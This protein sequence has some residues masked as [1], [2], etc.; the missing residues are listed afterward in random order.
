[1][2]KKRLP[3]L[4]R[5]SLIT[6]ASIDRKGKGKATAAD[7]DT[8]VTTIPDDDDDDDDDDY[9]PADPNLTP[10]PPPRFTPSAPPRPGPSRQLGTIDSQAY[11]R[12]R[13]E[14]PGARRLGRP[15]SVSLPRAAGSGPRSVEAGRARAASVVGTPSRDAAPRTPPIAA[16]TRGGVKRR[17]EAEAKAKLPSASGPVSKKARMAK[18]APG[19]VA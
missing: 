18:A 7:P 13:A 1:M 15:V 14:H 17:A 19:G 11:R 6:T 4:T 16:R 12:I 8:D 2:P 5:I 9:S 3:R 10:G